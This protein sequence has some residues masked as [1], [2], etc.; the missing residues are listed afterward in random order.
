MQT[1]VDIVSLSPD[2]ARIYLTLVI[3]DSRLCD[4]Y[5]AGGTHR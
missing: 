5:E 1:A 4:L 2:T 3:R